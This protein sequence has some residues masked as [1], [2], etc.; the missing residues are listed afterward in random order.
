MWRTWKVPSIR[1][2]WNDASEIHEFKYFTLANFSPCR[3]MLLFMSKAV[4]YQKKLL[5]FRVN[6]TEALYNNLFQNLR[7][8]VSWATHSHHDTRSL[9]S[10][11]HFLSI[12]DTCA[13]KKISIWLFWSFNIN[14]NILNFRIIEKCFK[15]N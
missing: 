4:Y 9:R 10:I 5:E 14:C 15:D 2:K 6:A 1:N 13:F 8:I 7:Y 11:F 12:R 3:Y